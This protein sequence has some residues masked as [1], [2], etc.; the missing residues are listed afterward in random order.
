MVVSAAGKLHFRYISSFFI[1]QES[2]K[3]YGITTVSRANILKS[4]PNNHSIQIIDQDGHFLCYIH[5]S[6][7]RRPWVFVWIPEANSLCL[8]IYQVK[9]KKSWTKLKHT[10]IK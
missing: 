2:F 7:L 5:K 9:W 10:V 3:P 1:T 4:D 6:G 8:N